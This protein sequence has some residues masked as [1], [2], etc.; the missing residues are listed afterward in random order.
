MTT[1]H[2]CPP[3]EEI[4]ALL[5]GRLEKQDRLRVIQHLDECPDCYEVFIGAA[6]FLE[7][8]SAAE[9]PLEDCED[10][11]TALKGKVVK[12]PPPLGGST[13]VRRWLP[14]TA[15]AALAIAVGVPVYRT[16]L[17]P[18]RIGSPDALIRSLEGTPGPQKILWALEA[19]R[20]E[21]ESHKRRASAFL[22]GAYLVDRQYSLKEGDA[23]SAAPYSQQ[24]GTALK[25][26]REDDLA[27]RFYSDWQKAEKTSPQVLLRDMRDSDEA[28][29]RV[30]LTEEVAGHYPY[31]AFGKWTE[32][33][34]LAAVT[35]NSEFFEQRDYRRF[36]TY[37]LKEEG[38]NLDD[39]VRQNLQGTKEILDAGDLKEKNLQELA[40]LLGGIIKFFEN[41]AE[42]IED[43]EAQEPAYF[44]ED[45]G[46]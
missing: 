3:I 20:G 12:F 8:E 37:F 29:E 32:A 16:F 6:E 23:P 11:A 30:R 2:T 39:D 46:S 18:P 44:N 45:P 1:T 36:P 26:L 7:V 10:W 31:F 43:F 22:I 13:A 33:T 42:A 5:D 25:N 15:A 9:Q 4:A 28:R 19:N 17:A 24:I 40:G 35:K 27:D 41:E 34:R 21:E 14:L 38:Q